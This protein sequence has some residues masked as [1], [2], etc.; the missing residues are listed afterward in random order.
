[1]PTDQTQKSE[2]GN[3]VFLP[4]P[5]STSPLC[6]DAQKVELQGSQPGESQVT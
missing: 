5:L 2:N 6:V 4:S 3:H 1:M